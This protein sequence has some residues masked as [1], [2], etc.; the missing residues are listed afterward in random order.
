[1]VIHPQPSIQQ[2]VDQRGVIRQEDHIT[3]ASSVILTEFSR[4]CLRW[5]GHLVDMHI[6]HPPLPA[7]N[8]LPF[9]NSDLFS[10]S[11]VYLS[12]GRKEPR[13]SVIWHVIDTPIGD[14]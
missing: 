10:G 12:E 5:E 6:P 13:R 7:P 4:C 11:I 1:G 2:Q 14:E 8:R 3:L 9:H